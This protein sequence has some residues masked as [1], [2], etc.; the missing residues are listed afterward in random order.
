MPLNDTT[1]KVWSMGLSKLNSYKLVVF[2]IPKCTLNWTTFKW[3]S[4]PKAR[5]MGTVLVS[6]CC[7][8]KGPQV[9]GLNHRN[10][11]GGGQKSLNK[12]VSRAA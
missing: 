12:I 9:N 3:I 11:S 2:L 10:Y 1:E 6:Y 4:K 7:W 8:N 5:F